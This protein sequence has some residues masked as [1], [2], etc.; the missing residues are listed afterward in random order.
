MVVKKKPGIQGLKGDGRIS[1]RYHPHIK[2]ALEFLAHEDQRTLSSYLE[3]LFID[4][5][6]DSLDNEIDADGQITGQPEI[7]PSLRRR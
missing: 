5:L 7:R 3:R 4:H 6:R 2:M 1:L